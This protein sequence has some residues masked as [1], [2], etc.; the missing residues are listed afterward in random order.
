MQFLNRGL[1]AAGQIYPLF[2]PGP[3]DILKPGIAKS[4]IKTLKTIS[5]ILK[6]KENEMPEVIGIMAS[7]IVLSLL[8]N[9]I[10]ERYEKGSR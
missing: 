9:V 5:K 6:L 7:C 2:V 3:L 1:V 4:V 10:K 8:Q